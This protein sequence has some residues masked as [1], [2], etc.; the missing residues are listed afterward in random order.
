MVC[1]P[2]LERE[3]A[4]KTKYIIWTESSELLSEGTDQITA[5]LS[6][7]KAGS[8]PPLGAKLDPH[9]PWEQAVPASERKK[10]ALGQD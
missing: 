7:R 6:G 5:Q 2:W 10:D 3:Q 9:L 1:N 4:K 8:S